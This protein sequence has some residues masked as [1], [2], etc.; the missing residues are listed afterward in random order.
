MS[1][2][3]GQMAADTSTSWPSDF[4][5][6]WWQEDAYSFSLFFSFNAFGIF[7]PGVRYYVR[8]ICV[9]VFSIDK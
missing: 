9:I 7:L 4:M 1:S 6:V 2:I 5:A 8:S 3:M